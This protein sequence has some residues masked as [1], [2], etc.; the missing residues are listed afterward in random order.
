MFSIVVAAAAA[1]GDDMNADDGDDVVGG[2]D[3]GV[4]L[5]RTVTEL[6]RDRQRLDDERRAV[7]DELTAAQQR[8]TELDEARQRVT[9]LETQLARHSSQ[10]QF[11]SLSVYIGLLQGPDLRKSFI[12]FYLL[13][14]IFLLSHFC[15]YVIVPLFNSVM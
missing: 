11:T 1:V 15:I 13:F 9:S 10:A 8:L 12:L 3:E 14:Y 4:E 7:V 5:A 2:D 6:R